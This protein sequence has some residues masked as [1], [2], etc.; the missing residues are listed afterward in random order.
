MSTTEAFPQICAEEATCLDEMASTLV[1]RR[2]LLVLYLKHFQICYL[3]FEQGRHKEVLDQWKSSFLDVEGR[4]RFI[5]AKGKARR[6]AVTC[7]LNDLG[8]LIVRTADGRVETLFAED[9]SVSRK[10]L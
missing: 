10:R 8:A 6:E 2:Q 4:R 3:M 1:P 5:S 9:V 7:G